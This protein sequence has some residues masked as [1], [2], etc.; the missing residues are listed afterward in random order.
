MSVMVAVH[1]VTTVLVCLWVAIRFATSVSLSLRDYLDWTGITTQ[2]IPILIKSRAFWFVFSMHLIGFG[3]LWTY[4]TWAQYP[5]YSFDNYYNANRELDWVRGIEMVFF[6]PFREEV[7]F[8]VIVYSI[9]YRRS[10]GNRLISI[11]ATNLLFGLVH[12]SNAFGHRYGPV[13]IAM[14]VALGMLIGTYYSI[15]FAKANSFWET[16]ALHM[17]NNVFSSLVPLS[18]ANDL[19]NPI[20][21]TGLIQTIIVYGGLV[22]YEGRSLW[23]EPIIA[24]PEAWVDSAATTK[25]S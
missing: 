12:L 7:I 5:I 25:T 2:P 10:G 23:N 3:V 16:L 14:Q 20:V 19:S 18:F 13:Y 1:G 22:I 4:Q 15:R 17:T 9:C 11:G 6:S 24:K 8:R 21:W